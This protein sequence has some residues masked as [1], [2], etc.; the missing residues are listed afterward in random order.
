VTTAVAEALAASAPSF[1]DLTPSE[2]RYMLARHRFGRLAYTFH[3]R[4]DVEPIAYVSVGGALVFRTAPGSKLQTLAHHPWVALEIDEV[5]GVHDW[6]SVVVH[7][8][9]YVLHEEG[10]LAEARAYRSAV[11]ALRELDAKALAE[12]DPV[13]LRNIVAKLHIDRMTGRTAQDPDPGW[14]GPTSYRPK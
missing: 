13:P 7:G 6:R 1:R 10:S 12:G 9:V 3:D 11:R 2:C 5:E 14:M 8:T 4:V